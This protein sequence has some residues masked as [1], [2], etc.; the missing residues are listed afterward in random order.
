M[1]LTLVTALFDLAARHTTTRRSMEWL[2]E[3]GQP[4]FGLP[5]PMVIFAERH[6]IGKLVHERAIRGH[7]SKTHVIEMPFEDLPHYHEWRSCDP[8]PS[9]IENRNRERDH[10]DNLS[11]NWEKPD[12]IAQVAR[13]NPF[14]T[15]HIGWINLGIQNVKVFDYEGWEDAFD[16]PDKVRIH[17]Q[18]YLNHA[19]VNEPEFYRWA[20]C[21]TAGGFLTGSVH[22]VVEFAHDFY[23]EFNR[24]W[25]SGLAP[26]DEDVIGTLV[27]Q[28]PEKYVISYG[29]YGQLFCNA[30]HPRW[31]GG[32]LVW[33][34]NRSLYWMIKTA[35]DYKDLPWAANLWHLI[36]DS[37][38]DGFFVDDT[39]LI[40]QFR[41]LLE[42]L[43]GGGNT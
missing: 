10:I 31:G 37:K 4:V 17:Q 43:K 30:K 5:Y 36:M 12:L 3:N 40:E 20:R 16:P 13:E 14:H 1:S 7:Y 9:L 24:V 25:R 32:S 26:H 11:I 38:R 33:A 22:S 39:T 15:T 29:D 28:N 19:I 23:Q 41:E 35:I 18:R 6:L 8:Q 27:V 34:Y 42:P 2:I 21:V